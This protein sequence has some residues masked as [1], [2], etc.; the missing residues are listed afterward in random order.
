MSRYTLPVGHVR[1]RESNPQQEQPMTMYVVTNEH[2][3]RI[4]IFNTDQINEYC[5]KISNGKQWK[6][7]RSSYGHRI[8][9][10]NDVLF[11]REIPKP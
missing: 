5:N 8:F 10:N 6:V 7:L 9:I 1:G 11:V 4:G 3:H 2:G